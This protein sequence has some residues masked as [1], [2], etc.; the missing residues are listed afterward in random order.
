[1]ADKAIVG[2]TADG[3][4]KASFGLIALGKVSPFELWQ[5]LP[6]TLGDVWNLA[7]ISN[8]YSRP[9]TPE[10][11]AALVLKL[12]TFMEEIPSLV[13]ASETIPAKLCRK[14]R[15]RNS[16][17]SV[18]QYATY[19][20]TELVL[21]EDLRKV[22][23]TDPTTWRDLFIVLASVDEAEFIAAWTAAK[24]ETVEQFGR[25]FTHGRFLTSPS[26]V[27][28]AVKPEPRPPL[29]TPKEES[30]YALELS[31]SSSDSDSGSFNAVRESL[32]CFYC[33]RQRHAVNECFKLADHLKSNAKNPDQI[34]VILKAL[35]F[36]QE[37]ID[38]F[39][40]RSS[41]AKSNKARKVNKPRS[42]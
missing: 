13:L 17:E 38:Q 3:L 1:M 15:R 23:F 34:K 40:S 5:A 41:K 10:E 4:R 18:V 21:D 22:S 2:L 7:L 29:L 20:H 12:I 33:G 36:P 37:A 35:S 14:L 16:D 32:T 24:V 31:D 6:A 27:A 9:T 19:F 26:V 30:F 25:V 28:S 42:K 8:N 11:A 39:L